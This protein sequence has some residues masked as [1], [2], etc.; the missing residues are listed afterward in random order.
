MVNHKMQ[1]NTPQDGI[2]DKKKMVQ[3]HLSMFF[4]PSFFIWAALGDEQMSSLDD[5]FPY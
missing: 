1:V 3:F 5:H 2:W 4:N